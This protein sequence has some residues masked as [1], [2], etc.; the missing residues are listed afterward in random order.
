[1]TWAIDSG[2]IA[3]N[4][5]YD[6]VISLTTG[7]TQ[8]DDVGIATRPLGPIVAGSGQKVWFEAE[9]SIASIAAAKGMYVGLSTLAGLGSKLTIV[10]ASGT[11]ASNTLGTSA[12][13][14]GYGFWMHGDV[15]G[16]FDAI[17]YNDITT[18]V[19]PG[20]GSTA[21]LIG[22]QPP[23]G[24]GTS[25]VGGGLLLANVLTA[26]SSYNPNVANAQNPPFTS[27]PTA[28]GTLIA[29]TTS[30]VSITSAAGTVATFTPQQCLDQLGLPPVSGAAAGATGFV[31]LGIRY[32]GQ[33]Y[34]YWYVNGYQVAKL[35]VTTYQDQVSDFAG[36]VQGS[37]GTA[38][39]NAFNINWIRAAALRIP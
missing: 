20:T 21:A 7:S 14:S 23:T 13:Q 18:A 32:D 39:T 37:A 33:Q 12:G 6:H 9:I 38:A 27:V 26:T 31:K 30:N 35:A 15:I 29:T 16:N 3:W 5:A 19:T 4:T 22:N 10:A 2:S 34:V 1:M 28:P 24:N 25:A 8:S 17:W 36:I 11:K